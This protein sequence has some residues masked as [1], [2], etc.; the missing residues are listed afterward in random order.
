MAITDAFTGTNGTGL[1]AYSA[2]W[3]YVRGGTTNF[4]I[5]TNAVACTNGL[6]AH[7]FARRTETT[8]PT[9]HYAQ[10]VLSVAS[11]DGSVAMGVAVRCGAA[12]SGNGYG[13]FAAGGDNYVIELAGGSETTLGNGGAV[14]GVGSVMKFTAT[15][16]TLAPLDDGSATNT[17]GNQTDATFATGVPGISAYNDPQATSVCRIDSFECSDVSAGGSSLV[18]IAQR[19]YRGH[20]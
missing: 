11:D 9:D 7:L 6:G 14:I 16:T 10:C 4:Q 20:R 3:A 5:Q 13:F 1:A 2:N 17:P 8:F 15:G 12:A 19:S 18:A